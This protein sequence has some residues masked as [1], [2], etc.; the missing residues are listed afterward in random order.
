[1]FNTIKLFFIKFW[2]CIKRKLNLTVA[3]ARLFHYHISQ[4]TINL[5]TAENL[6][7]PRTEKAVNITNYINIEKTICLICD[8]NSTLTNT[9]D[10]SL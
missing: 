8:T 9:Y 6:S 5:I 10:E 7:Y 2:L 1:M 3:N 4:K